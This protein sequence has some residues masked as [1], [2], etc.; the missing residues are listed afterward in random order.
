MGAPAVSGALKV[1][2]ADRRNQRDE[3]RPNIEADALAYIQENNPILE[4]LDRLQR[5]EI[6]KMLGTSSAN[7]NQNRP[8]LDPNWARY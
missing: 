2:I 3:P 8:P 7:S 4:T 5:P 1:L 6:E